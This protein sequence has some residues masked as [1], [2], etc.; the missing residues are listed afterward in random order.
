MR[1]AAMLS[2]SHPLPEDHRGSPPNRGGPRSAPHVPAD[3]SDGDLELSAVRHQPEGLE[4][5]QAQTKF[6]KKELQSLYRGFKSVSA[7][8]RVSGSGRS[9]MGLTRC[10]LLPPQECPSGR[11]DEETFTLIY[12]QFFPQGGEWGRPGVASPPQKKKIRGAPT[13]PLPLSPLRRRQRLR[14]LLVHRLRRRRQRGA[15]LRGEQWGGHQCHGGTPVPQGDVGA[16]T[17][18]S[19]EVAGL[20]ASVPSSVIH[21]IGVPGRC[22]VRRASR[23]GTRR[24]FARS[25][26]AGPNGGAPP[27]RKSAAPSPAGAGGLRGACGS[28]W[29]IPG[30]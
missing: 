23:A 30:D 19:A 14:S 3:S 7:Q 12:A 15:L 10:P 4:Q 20:D 18:G 6:T 11:V 25:G 16:T 28:S 26:S 8:G 24:G 17:L 21:Q 22:C 2:P 9:P 29:H 27:P 13:P 1:G 5:L